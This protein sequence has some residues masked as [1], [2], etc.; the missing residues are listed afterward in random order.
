MESCLQILKTHLH[1][2]NAY[3]QQ[4]SHGGDLPKG[5]PAI[6]LQDSL[7]TLSNE[8]TWQIK[9]YFQYQKAYDHQTWQGGNLLWM[10]PAHK[11]TWSFDPMVMQHHMTNQ[12]YISSTKPM[13]T[14]LER[15]VTYLEGRLP[16]NSHEALTMWSYEITWKI[17]NISPI[18]LCLWPPNLA[19]C[20]LSLSNSQLKVNQLFGHIAL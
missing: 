3:G 9:T 4:T 2:H 12:I 17:K 7:I 18:P 14:K 11:F 15:I 20:W 13:A 16:M 19:G 8:I 6:K 1:Y 5:L 10:A